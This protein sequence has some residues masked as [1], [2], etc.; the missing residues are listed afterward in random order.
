MRYLA[1]LL[2]LVATPAFAQ[3][4]YA[5]P[6]EHRTDEVSTWLAVAFIA[7]AGWADPKHAKGEADH[8]A[9]YHVLRWRWLNV[10][11]EKDFVKVISSYVAAFDPRGS[12]GTRVRWLVSLIGKEPGAAPVG[13][14]HEK[15]SWELHRKWWLQAQAR[16]KRCMAGRCADPYK[17][18]ARHWGGGMDVPSVCMRPLPN[19]G[20]FNTFFSVD[21]ACVRERRRALREAARGK[22]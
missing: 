13:W 4:K 15:A 16:A 18:M 5:V 21:Y 14:P 17:G 19:A 20:T 12:K 22:P 7:E 9:I 8:R 11:P 6:I 3:E 10:F 2:T 1:L